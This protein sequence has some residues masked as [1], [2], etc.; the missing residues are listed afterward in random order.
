MKIGQP[1]SSD[2]PQCVGRPVWII[3]HRYLVTTTMAELREWI[4]IHT[5][6]PTIEAAKAAYNDCVETPHEIDT[7]FDERNSNNCDW[8]NDDNLFDSL[9][10]GAISPYRCLGAA[11]VVVR[12][13]DGS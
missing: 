10:M 11:L 8:V 13:M 6:S 7:P 5:K 9:Q 4:G 12:W 2:A 3:R 1:V